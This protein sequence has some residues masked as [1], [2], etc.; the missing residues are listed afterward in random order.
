MTVRVNPGE[1]YI[2]RRLEREKRHG[3]IERIDSHTC[4]FT[5]EV[6]DAAEMLPNCIHTEK[7]HMSAVAAEQI[8]A[9]CL[10]TAVK[11]A[12]NGRTPLI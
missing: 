6:Y 7:R 12:F 1:G 10:R 2:L 3:T 9:S 4:K 11:S 5:A 8:L